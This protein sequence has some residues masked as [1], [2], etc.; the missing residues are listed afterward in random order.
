MAAWLGYSIL[1][2]SSFAGSRGE[3][4]GSDVAAG[5]ETTMAAKE[6]AMRIKSI[7]RSM[8]PFP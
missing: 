3:A 8:V 6:T 7:L 4:A 1:D 2:R 5:L